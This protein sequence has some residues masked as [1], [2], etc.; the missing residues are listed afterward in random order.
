LP[1]PAFTNIKK[2]LLL[3]WVIFLIVNFAFLEDFFNKN[4]L[5]GNL[6]ATEGFVLLVFCMLYYLAELKY[7]KQDIAGG[8]VFWVVTGLS[9]YVVINFFLFLFYKPLLKVNVELSVSLW[10]IHNIAYII[11][12]VFLTKAFYGTVRTKHRG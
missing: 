8:P 6:L 4:S 5:S 7:D 3:I 1:R 10:N 12:C 11:L 2:T 9:I